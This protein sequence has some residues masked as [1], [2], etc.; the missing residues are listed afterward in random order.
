M[1]LLCHVCKSL[2][3]QKYRNAGCR[4]TCCASR[5][6]ALSVYMMYETGIIYDGHQ[7]N[8]IG[9]GKSGERKPLLHFLTDMPVTK[10]TVKE[11][12][13][14]GMRRGLSE[15]QRINTQKNHR[16][17][18]EHQFSHKYQTWKKQYYLIQ[19]EHMISQTW[20]YGKILEKG[21]A[22]QEA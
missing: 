15:N 10:N 8:F 11:L 9:S 20:M 3:L 22:E 12:A 5:R 18:L 2:V 7:I 1:H 13:E 21:M 14:D 4:Y 17:S 16:Y 6:E 19:I